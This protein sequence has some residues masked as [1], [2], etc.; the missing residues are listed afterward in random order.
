MPPGTATTVRLVLEPGQ[1]V[2]FCNQPGHYKA[3]MERRFTVVR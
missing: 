3:G 2:A 1:Y